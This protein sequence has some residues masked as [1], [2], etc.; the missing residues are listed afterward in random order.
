MLPC[1][2]WWYLWFLE[3]RS[4]LGEDIC[5]IFWWMVTIEG[6]A[7]VSSRDISATSGEG[8]LGI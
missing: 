2:Q 7:I 4:Y 3:W 5:D 8:S 1:K 6:A